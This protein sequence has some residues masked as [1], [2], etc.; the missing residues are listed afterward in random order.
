LVT[1]L[2]ARL[3][4][5]NASFALNGTNLV[6]SVHDVHDLTGD[7]DSV[8]GLRFNSNGEQ[9]LTGTDAAGRVPVAGSSDTNVGLVVPLN[10]TTPTDANGVK[11]L[12]T[13]TVDIKP[14]LSVP[15]ATY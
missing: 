1:A 12:E 8:L 15:N 14:T 5:A 7:P 11:V 4:D 10:T 13:S 9:T 2:R 3:G 6:L